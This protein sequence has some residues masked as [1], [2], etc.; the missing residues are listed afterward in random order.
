MNILID[1]Q[2]LHTYERTRGIGYYFINIVN[3]I[4]GLGHNVLI[5]SYKDINTD[6]L[7][8]AI[9]S[10]AEV[11][12]VNTDYGHCKNDLLATQ[13]GQEL[14][15]IVTNKKVDV[16]WNPNPLMDNVVFSGK[17]KWCI[18]LATVH[19]LIPLVFK[20]EYLDTADNAVFDEYISRLIKLK[21]FD[22]IIAVSHSTKED[23]LKY[24][25]IAQSAVTVVHEGVNDKFFLKPSVDD[26]EEVSL[27]YGL[28]ENY[29]F[30]LSGPN[31]RKN[32]HKLIVAVAILI[33]NYKKD[34]HLVI[35]S[36]FDQ[37][38]REML[39][40]YA[41][42]HGVGERLMFA[43]AIPDGDMPI[44]YRL[45]KVFV[46]ASLYEGFGLPLVEAMAAGSPIAASGNS[47]IPEVTG[48][49]AILFDPNDPS[50]IAK[51]T[52]MILEDEQL[53][54]RLSKN[55]TLRAR[56]FNWRDAAIQTIKLF[57]SLVKKPATASKTLSMQINRKMRLAFFSPLNPQ[58]SGISDYSESLL[59][60]LKEYA[61]INLFVD[62]ITPSNPDIVNN[63]K[64]YDYKEFEDLN[65]KNK[66]D[67]IIY[68]IGNNTL[69][70]YIY[71]MLQRYPGITVLH[72]FNISSF[73]RHI[74]I[75]KDKPED[76]LKEVED[77]YGV[78]GKFISERV[79]K[80]DYDLDL[81]KFALNNKIIASSKAVIVHSQ[82][83]KNQ[84][85]CNNVFIIPMG[86]DLEPEITPEL[87]STIRKEKGIPDETFVISC[88]G[89][90]V[91]TKRIDVVI[92]AFSIFRLFFSDAK[93]FLVG[94]CHSEMEEIIH[95]LLERYNLHDSICITGRVDLEDFKKYMKAS[96]VIMNLRYPT[97]G[98]TSA[99]LLRAFSYGKPVIISNVNQ[100]REFPDDCCLKVEVGDREQDMIL[101]HLIRLKRDPL[102]RKRLDE[103]ERRY[104]E[105]NCSWEK[106][107][108]KYLEVITL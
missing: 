81:Y 7:P 68:H 49:A 55:G 13:Y 60:H 8:E 10:K 69:H 35:G 21:S 16:F 61:E 40:A 31:F 46:F 26:L 70:E 22:N 90:I 74:T 18:N 45:S 82:W 6:G 73:V 89:D 25:E 98:E 97:M 107:T 104:I 87:M 12:L 88:F 62:G 106:V 65:I 43:G 94:K 95:R 93:L 80:K 24:L 59:K 3:E 103:N 23:I 2:T 101:S 84:I 29:I 64:H 85:A 34:I 5:A 32:N 14:E 11:L 47:S 57:E 78:L 54:S 102:L 77:C 108:K 51:K 72:D 9:K 56:S 99:S 33:N 42:E 86:A 66:Y 1:G 63:F 52:A 37:Q 96:D 75:V 4:I 30:T 39:K 28:P 53:A 76:Y 27:R 36:E 19:D 50:D 44:I 100:F 15:D 79:N 83:V 91:H 48:D 38:S 71:I 105:E 41:R 58:H 67:Q 17:I 92:K 20:T